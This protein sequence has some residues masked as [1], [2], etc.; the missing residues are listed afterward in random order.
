M[1]VNANL[2]AAAEAGAPALAKLVQNPGCSRSGRQLLHSFLL[3]FS[4]LSHVENAPGTA[5][6]LDRVRKRVFE[7]PS[8]LASI[9]EALEGSSPS[10]ETRCSDFPLIRKA[11]SLHIHWLFP[12][13]RGRI[14]CWP[15]FVG[16]ASLQQYAMDVLMP[17]RESLTGLPVNRE[18]VK[19]FCW[20]LVNTGQARMLG[21]STLSALLTH[22]GILATLG[23]A[24]ESQADPPSLIAS[25]ELLRQAWFHFSAQQ[26]LPGS[27]PEALGAM[28]SA[29]MGAARQ[30]IVVQ[31]LRAVAPAQRER[32]V[33]RARRAGFLRVRASTTTEATDAY[34]QHFNRQLG[35]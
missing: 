11:V 21:E 8:A 20:F 25:T 28:Q 33:R 4:F 5:P 32:A 35:S 17:E 26:R 16:A 18:V 24:A 12:K 30:G 34:V 3:P 1:Y 31:L 15:A 2:H 23:A 7:R 10:D 6:L 22:E 27:S 9:V 13:S 29:M 19:P 14:D